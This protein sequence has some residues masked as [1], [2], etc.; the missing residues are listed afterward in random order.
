MSSTPPRP[1]WSG[2]VGR[3]AERDHAHQPP[4]LPLSVAG[5]LRDFRPPMAPLPTE[6]LVVVL[7]EEMTLYRACGGD[8]PAAVEASLRSNYEIR[9]SPP[10]PAD[11]HATVLHM[12][13]SMFARADTISRM[14][15]RNPDR[16]GTHVAQLRL[17]PG[18]G[19]CLADTGSAGHWS[20]WG[21]PAQLAAFVTDTWSVS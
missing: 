19:I 3:A 1:V 13:V 11:L 5:S 9:R 6:I 12:A 18:N 14:A 21:T 20:V 7:Q 4:P 8:T 16:I 10:H 15:R 17:A 2:Q